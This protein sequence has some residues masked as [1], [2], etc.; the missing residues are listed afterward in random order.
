MQRKYLVLAAALALPLGANAQSSG[1]DVGVQNNSP[2]D[3]SIIS[4]LLQKHD[5]AFILYP[6]ESNY[7]LYTYTS[8]MNKGAIES[9]NWGHNA[10]KDELKFQLSLAFPIWRGILGDNSVLAASYTQRSWWQI[11][12]SK[13]S[14]PFRETNYEPQLFVGWATTIRWATGRCVT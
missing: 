4:N 14:S 11:S 1:Y 8:N 10:R 2:V 5:S 9:Y 7:V 13:E 6:Y 3:G 12:N